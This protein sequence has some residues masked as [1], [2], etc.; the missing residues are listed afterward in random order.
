MK[1]WL[2]FLLGGQKREVEEKGLGSSNVTV[3]LIFH[4]VLNCLVFQTKKV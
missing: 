3:L 2:C 4:Y 1:Q